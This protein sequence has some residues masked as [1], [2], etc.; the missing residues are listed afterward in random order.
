MLI[1]KEALNEF[2]SDRILNLVEATPEIREYENKVEKIAQEI[3]DLVPSLHDKVW[4]L[5]DDIESN[6]GMIAAIREELA[7][8]Q[9]IKDGLEMKEF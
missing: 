4:Q 3:L 8:K 2:L 9:G 1:M 7:Y 6:D 5:L